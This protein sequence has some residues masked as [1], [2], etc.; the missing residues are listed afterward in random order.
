MDLRDLNV[1]LDQ[2]PSPPSVAVKLLELYSFQEI[3]FDELVK[4]ISIDP[5]LT[6]R[7]INYCNSPLMARANKVRTLNQAIVALGMNAVRMIA[8]SFSLVEIK[9]KTNHDF[10]YNMFWGHSMATAVAA[11][12]LCAKI[13]L[14]ADMGFLAGLML[15]IGS[16]PLSFRFP[17]TFDEL[18]DSQFANIEELA[19]LENNLLGFNRF[20]VGASLLK[21]WLF[22]DEIIKT[23]D[24]LSGLESGKWTTHQR[25]M[26]HV[27]TLARA[28]SAL[29]FNSNVEFVWIDTTR[30]RVIEL[31]DVDAAEFEQVF[32]EIKS[33]WSQFASLLDLKN[34]GARSLQEIEIEARRK[35]TTL[36]LNQLQ[37]LQRIEDENKEL[38]SSIDVDTLTGIKNRRAYEETSMAEF[39]RANRMKRPFSVAVVDIDR[40]KQVNDTF[41]HLAGDLALKHVANTISSNIRKYD[42]VYRYGGEEFVV[43]LLEC[44]RVQ[45]LTCAERIRI[46]VEESD[47]TTNGHRIPLTVSVGVATNNNPDFR[48]VEDLFKCADARMYLAK[49]NGRNRSVG[50]DLPLGPQSSLA[51][52]CATEYSEVN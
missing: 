41:G 22:P 40:F 14:D 52:T 38:K 45:A 7:I 23:L 8:L 24:S 39:S 28:I 11:K 1:Q 37:Q 36:A 42:N 15:D 29:F 48:T 35:M 5:A 49:R 50:E 27:L 17:D 4:T 43:L 33:G 13:G 20:Q 31:L 21:A 6:A 44:N 16:I 25:T 47:F 32:D 3:E 46:A 19:Q 12:E 34:V 51:T 2:L 30:N 9:S 26:E 18:Q 10:D